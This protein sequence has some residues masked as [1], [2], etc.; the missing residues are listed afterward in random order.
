ML[1]CLQRSKSSLKPAC[2]C[3]KQS[4]LSTDESCVGENPL[5]THLLSEAYRQFPCGELEK[6]YLLFFMKWTHFIMSTNSI[7]K[8]LATKFIA[9]TASAWWAKNL[10]QEII[11]VLSLD[12]VNALENL[13]ACLPELYKNKNREEAEKAKLYEKEMG[14][15]ERRE[16]EKFR[17]GRESDPRDDPDWRPY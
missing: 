12:P 16:R 11:G 9:G 17:T 1:Y 15:R 6:Q 3:H 14:E 7:S 10:A 8:T 13:K 5:T 2:E 4:I